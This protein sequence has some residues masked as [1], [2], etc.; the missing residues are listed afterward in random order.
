MLQHPWQGNIR[1]LINTLSRAAIWVPGEIIQ[2]EDI[3][4]A[5]FSAGR[6]TPQND[7]ILNRPIGEGF[8]L[9]ELIAE[10][11]KHYLKRAI[12]EAK[13]NKTLA[14]KLTGLP[15]YQT[16]INWMNKHR[17]VF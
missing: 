7:S 13:G 6:A 12:E 4:E 1:E 16:F 11:S 10:V 5:L 8:C 15:N 14:A 9:P 17:I 2:T 3:K